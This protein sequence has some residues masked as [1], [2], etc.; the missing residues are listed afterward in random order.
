MTTLEAIYEDGIFKPL[1]RVPRELKEHD[2]VRIT[3]ETGD[4]DEL[5]SEFAEW[6]AASEQDLNRLENS[7][8][9]SR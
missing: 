1:S 5:I 7:L 8:G 6:E 2:R 9:E 4:N 3:I